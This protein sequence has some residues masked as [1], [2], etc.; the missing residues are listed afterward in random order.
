MGGSIPNTQKKAD[1]FALIVLELA[2]HYINL[3]VIQK[4]FAWLSR[5]SVCHSKRSF[6]MSGQS[7]QLSEIF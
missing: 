6:C 5:Q 7:F 1:A 4:L 3:Q 2:G